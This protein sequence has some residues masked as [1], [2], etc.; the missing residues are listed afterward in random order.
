MKKTF[1]VWVCL[2]ALGHWW[3]RCSGKALQE[4]KY[5]FLAENNGAVRRTFQNKYWFGSS[6]RNSAKVQ[7]EI[8]QDE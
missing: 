2:C 5:Q 8:V 1:I 6:D 7:G 4:I 3:S